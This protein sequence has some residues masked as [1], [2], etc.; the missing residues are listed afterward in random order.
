VRL[1]RIRIDGFEGEGIGWQQCVDI[2][3]QDCEVRACDGNG[4]H[5]GS[6]SVRWVVRRV[7]S[8]LNR[9]NGLFYCLRTQYGLVEESTFS[10]NAKSGLSVNSHDGR[11]WIKNCQI[12]GNGQSGVVFPEA[13]SHGAPDFCRIEDCRFL[14][15][16]RQGGKAELQIDAAVRGIY[17]LRNSIEPSLDAETPILPLAAGPGLLGLTTDIHGVG[18]VGNDGDCPQL[19]PVA[20]PADAARHLGI[21]RLAPWSE[22]SEGP[23]Q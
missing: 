9:G 1:E 17:V 11:Q 19:G 10:G 21:S 5:P 14:R 6:G 7:N 16:C 22:P 13:T 8:S 20:A 3:V 4:L 18:A 15:N 23:N 2:V 12:E